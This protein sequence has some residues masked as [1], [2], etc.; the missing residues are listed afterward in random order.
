M[1]TMKARTC[2]LAAMLLLS[3]QAVFSQSLDDVKKDLYYEHFITAKQNLQKIISSKPSADAYY[4]LGVADMGLDDLDAA[5]ADFQK[6]LQTDGNSPLAYVGQGR[7][8]IAADKNFAAA[9]QA[10]QKAW[11]LSEGRDFDV[12]RA[13]LEATALSPKTDAQFA[14][15]LVKQFQD[16][17]KNRK[18]EL[19]AAD[20]T[21][22]GNVYANLPDGGGPAATKYETAETTDPKYA[23]AFYE[24]GNLWDRAKQDSLAIK[25]WSSA[26]NADPNYGPALYQMFT[27][28]RYRDL[29][30][31]KSYLDKYMALTDDPT[32]AKINLVDVLYLQKNYQ[33]AIDQANQL[34][35][36]NINKVTKTRLYKLIAV[37]QLAQGDSLGAKKN[38]DTYFQSQ[39]TDKILPFDYKTYAD[40]M[41]KLGDEP[42]QLE[43]LNK[44]VNS[45]T[46]TNI[47]F[48]RKEAYDLREQGNF[49]AADL[50][51][52]KLFE[53]ADTA[54]LTMSDYYYRAFSKYGAA[55]KG[56]GSYDSS[57]AE[58]KNFIARFPDQPSGYYYIAQSLKAQDTGYTGAAIDAYNQYLSK[59]KPEDMK[60]KGEILKVIYSYIAGC[61]YTQ[62]DNDKALQ[63]TDKLME[64]EPHSPVAANIYANLA[65]KSAE[66]KDLDKATTMANKALEIDPN[67]QMAPKVI[68]YVKK[69]KD[70]NEK[71]RKYNE[72]KKKSGN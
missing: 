63:Y 21:A 39:D 28:Y 67:N 5:K 53:K 3:A 6:A 27:Y 24:E 9:K 18:Y 55:L 60:D 36:E 48:I 26:F 62:G 16:N 2:L 50:W 23:R 61:Y 43:Y 4:Y 20:Y 1:R 70:Y 13:I 40:I 42:A 22:I 64:L 72:S 49:K 56:L 65:F 17:R 12:L 66:A 41:G 33:Q 34:M 51:F 11:D 10:F 32:N 35:G 31:A 8:S 59:L 25:Y 44:F 46:S 14:L 45:D 71:M 52:N 57:V 29:D 19:T 7:I 58:W 54:Q 30:K 15:D 68:D 47:P 38:M 37:S 69:M